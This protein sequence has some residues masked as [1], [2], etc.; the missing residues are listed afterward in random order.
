MHLVIVI[1]E[2]KVPFAVLEWKERADQT[3]I[4]TRRHA[5]RRS[6]LEQPAVTVHRRSLPVGDDLERPL[7]SERG[8]VR[9][10]KRS[11]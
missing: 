5:A 1:V 7:L 2:P 4:C 6:I 9:L 8:A 11:I 10:V 3:R